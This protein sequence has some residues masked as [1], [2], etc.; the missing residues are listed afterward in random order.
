[1]VRLISERKK[2]IVGN[3]FKKDYDFDISFFPEHDGMDSFYD[4]ED[5]MLSVFDILTVGSSSYHVKDVEISSEDGI[6]HFTF[7]VSFIA[8][9]REDAVLMGDLVHMGDIKLKGLL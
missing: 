4:W 6:W 3:R 8:V 9:Q 7:A 5:T 1:M 2:R